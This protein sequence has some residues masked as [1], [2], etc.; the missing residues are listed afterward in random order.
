MGL[1]L[2]I[3][4]GHR[5]R[6]LAFKRGADAAQRGG[7]ERPKRREHD[8]AARCGFAPESQV[9]SRLTAGGS[10]IRTLGPP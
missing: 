1:R 8:A 2:R 9:R 5:A 7:A 10:G 3:A 4:G 6:V